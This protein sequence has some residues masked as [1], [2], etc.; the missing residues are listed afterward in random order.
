MPSTFTIARVNVVA[1]AGSVADIAMAWG[2]ADRSV[3]QRREL[4]FF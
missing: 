4:P 2:S 1:P 3:G